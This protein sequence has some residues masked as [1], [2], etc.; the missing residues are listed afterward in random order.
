MSI[1]QSHLVMLSGRRARAT[2]AIRLQVP[3]AERGLP[4]RMAPLEPA[5]SVR[6]S[7]ESWN[8]ATSAS[9][10]MTHSERSGF[11]LKPALECLNRGLE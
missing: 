7:S 11:Q 1:I 6:H 9:E 2:D 8:P 4:E 3:C 10:P 5:L